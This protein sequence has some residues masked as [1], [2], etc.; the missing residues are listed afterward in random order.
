RR[1]PGGALVFAIVVLPSRSA[2]LAEVTLGRV[3]GFSQVLWPSSQECPHSCRADTYLGVRGKREGE[4]GTYGGGCGV[5]WNSSG[6]RAELPRDWARRRRQV[7]RRDG[8]RCQIGGPSCQ[9]TA[10]EV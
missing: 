10:T 6:R 9:G 5:S 4:G 1:R 7:L 3:R 2:N 8:N